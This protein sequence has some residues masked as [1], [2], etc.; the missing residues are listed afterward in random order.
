MRL[1]D[2]LINHWPDLLVALVLGVMVDLFRVGSILR[3]SARRIKNKLAE[4]SVARL[5]KRISKLE[6]YRNTVSSYAD[7]ALYLGTLR[8]IIILL[9]YMS[10]GTLVL[11][12]DS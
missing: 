9:A 11:I 8:A 3:N 12:L 5:R 4:Q 10:I 6:S 7:K 1:I 2:W